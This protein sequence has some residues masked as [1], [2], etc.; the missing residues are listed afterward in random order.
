M[1]TCAPR[2]YGLEIAG[3]GCE[4]MLPGRIATRWSARSPRTTSCCHASTEMRVLRVHSLGT[5]PRLETLPDLE[6]GSDEVLVRMEATTISHHDLGVASGDVDHLEQPFPY[7]PGMEGAGR[8][9]DGTL[10]R[11]DGAGLGLS[12]AGTWADLVVAPKAAIVHVPQTISPAT[13]AACGSSADAAWAALYDVGALEE[14]ESVGVT[15]ARGSVGSLVVQLAA[16]H[17]VHMWS[18]DHMKDPDEPVDLLVDTVGG[19]DLPR[20]L[21]SVRMG[22]RA[23]L[24]GYTAG[25]NV[26]IDLPALLHGDV[27]LL[28]LN[29]Q[30][31][32]VAAD[33]RARL[34]DDFA[35]GRL[36][37][38]TDDIS[39]DELEA[40]IQRLQTGQAKGRLVLHW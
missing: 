37:M 32:Q 23:V 31:R 27:A 9:D 21:R 12:R 14:G 35:A 22:G 25:H 18:R 30:R 10:V 17:R 7:V 5:A 4:P 8:L 29:M 6:P 2:Q 15:G 38:Q 20:R 19:P 3:A 40:G 33:V 39:L 13:A 26:D 1:R 28:P 36:Q 16:G 34:I 24:L 11:L